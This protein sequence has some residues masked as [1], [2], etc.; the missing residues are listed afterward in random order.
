MTKRLLAV[1]ALVVGA[2]VLGEDVASACGDKFVL[3]GRGARVAR[4]KFPSTILIFMN[5][6]SRVPAADK[7]F[8]VEAVLKAA[9]HKAQVAESEAEVEKALASG[10]YDLVLADYNDVPALR[11]EA[12]VG[13]LEAG[14][15]AAPLQAHARRAHG[16]REGGGVPG[17]AVEGEP[18]SADRRRP[19]AGGEAQGGRGD[20]RRRRELRDA[21]VLRRVRRILAGLT[22]GLLA[23]ASA[24]G[25]AW[26]PPKGEAWLTFGYG[27]I[28]SAHHYFATASEDP[29]AGPTRSQTLG[30]VVGYGITDRFALNV[31]IPFVTSIYHGGRPHR[32]LNRRHPDAGRRPVPRDI[33]GLPDQPRLSGAE[34][35]GLHRPVRDRSD[36]EHTTIRPSRTRRPARASTSCCVGFAAGASLDR[37]V[38]RTF[39]EVYYDYAFVEEV[40]DINTNR[41]DFGFQAGY[42]ITPSLGLRFLAAGYYTHGGIAYN[43]LTVETL[44]REQ[45]LHHDQIAKSSNVSVGGGLSYVLTG[46][47]EV[48]VSYLRSIY[49]TYRAQDRPWHRLRLQLELLSRADHPQAYP[50]P[51]PDTLGPLD[52]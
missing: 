26:L 37:I 43:R 15:P 12:G 34:R 52:R 51:S 27:N 31:S 6:T 30:V 50:R 47:T 28:Y 7:E 9:G 40:I 4:S 11:K 20:L 21:V 33:S 44:S 38:P 39:A 48:S 41:S 2:V 32:D 35:N 3:L 25:Q 42:F 46:S 14:R 8:H 10:K 23:A 1:V 49:G 45:F 13:V 22:V 16:R 19:D 17:A 36:S 24:R 18:G 5:P 29:S